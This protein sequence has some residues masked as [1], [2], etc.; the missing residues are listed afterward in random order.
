MHH[1]S[2]VARAA[3]W[4]ATHKKTAIFGWLAFVLASIALGGAIGEKEMT[5]ADQYPGESGRAQQALEDSRLEPHTEMVIV[6]SRDG[7]TTLK[8]PEFR[9]AIDELTTELEGTP[10]VKEVRSPVG[11]AAP[12]AEDGRS[13]LVE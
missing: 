12:V 7:K 4:S 2:L 8:S 13:A 10:H 6:Q 11:G 5:T 9:A 1:T 3:R